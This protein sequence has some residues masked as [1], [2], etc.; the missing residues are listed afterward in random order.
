MVAYCL[1][2]SNSIHVVCTEEATTHTLYHAT[3]AIKGESVLG[4]QELLS[5]YPILSLPYRCTH[6][7]VHDNSPFVV[8]PES[9]SGSATSEEWLSLSTDIHSQK[10][11]SADFEEEKLKLVYTVSQEFYEFV[12]RSFSMPVFTHSV[13]P[14]LRVVL[15]QSRLQ[16]QQFISVLLDKDTLQVVLAKDGQ[17]LLA[18]AYTIVTEND[19]LYYITAIYRHFK[20]NPTEVPLFLYSREN[21]DTVIGR[22]RENIATVKH[23]YFQQYDFEINSK[24]HENPIPTPIIWQVLCE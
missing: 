23:N 22:L 1:M 20:L 14:H 11:L 8:L 16:S 13:E 24:S 12:T 9:L 18:N 3:I 19:L 2:D 4:L 5:L 15:R 10:V 21:N 17:L 7:M 6:V